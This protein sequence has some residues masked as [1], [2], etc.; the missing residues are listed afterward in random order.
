MI[1]ISLMKNSIKDILVTGDQSLTDIISCC[2]GKQVWYQIAPWKH[3]LARNLEKHLP[4]KYYGSFKR[5]IIKREI[6]FC[7]NSSAI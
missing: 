7:S 3:G 5:I 6:D 2:R 4:N 1:F